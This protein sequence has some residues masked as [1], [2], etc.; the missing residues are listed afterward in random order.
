[1]KIHSV[2]SITNLELLSSDEDFYKCQY[3]EHLLSVEENEAEKNNFDKEWK[4]FYIEKL[5]NWHLYCYKCDKKIIEYLIKWTEYRLKFNE[6]YN[7]NLLD[8]TV[9]F[10]LEYKIYQNSD[11]EWIKYLHKLLADKEKTVVTLQA[12]CSELQTAALKVSKLKKDCER[13]RKNACWKCQKIQKKLSFS[14]TNCEEFQFLFHDL[15][16]LKSDNSKSR[17]YHRN[18]F[19]FCSEISSLFSFF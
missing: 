8:S 12:Q 18:N 6:W 17:K 11:S 13:S 3:N 19:Y 1:M 9:K 5:L 15:K 16:Y 14:H 7:E 2:I 10:M 4:L